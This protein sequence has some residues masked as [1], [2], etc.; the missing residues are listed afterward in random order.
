[1]PVAGIG[2]PPV[3]LKVQGPVEEARL[4]FDFSQLQRYLSQRQGET[5]AQE[6]E[7]R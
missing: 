4:A 5:P 7:S 6:R 2:V 1:V 3:Q